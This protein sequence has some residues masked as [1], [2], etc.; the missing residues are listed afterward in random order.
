M[1]DVNSGMNVKSIRWSNVIYHNP[2]DLELFNHSAASFIL[3]HESQFKISN[4][5]A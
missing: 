1:M 5:M 2:P 4:S 3:D